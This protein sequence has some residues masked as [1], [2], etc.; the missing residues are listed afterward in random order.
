MISN[1]TLSLIGAFKSPI[2]ELTKE[3]KAE[4]TFFLDNGMSDYIENMSEKY[5]STKTFLFR[6][7]K[8]PFYDVYFSISL[9]LGEKKF[10]IKKIDDL[11][12]ECNYATII[13]NAGSGKSMLM[14]HLFLTSIESLYKIPIVIDLRSLNDFDGNLTDYLYQIIFNNK[15]SPNKKI[16]ERILSSDEFIF[17]LDGFDELYSAHKNKITSD[18]DSFIDRYSKNQ[19]II[20]SRPNSGI[21]SFPRFNNYFVQSLST[22]EI[23]SFVD[24][25]LRHEDYQFLA[26][27][28]KKAILRPENQDYINFL[29]SPLLLSMFIL[30]FNSY[31]ELPKKKSK[32]YWNV[33][34][35]LSTKHDAFTKKGGFQHERKTGLQNDDFETILKWF[36]YIS[37]F[38]GK[39]TFDSQY[40]TSKLGEI[41]NN[42][43]LKVNVQD[44]IDD[45]TLAISIII[46]DGIEYRFPHKSMQEYF[47]A[48]LIKD[49][50][51]EV[52]EKIYA[53]KLNL[54]VKMTF[55]GYENFWNLCCEL[56]KVNF[57]NFF[58]IR[59]LENFLKRL[60]GKND[61]T[62]VKEFYKIM[63]FA[64]GISIKAKDVIFNS[65]ILFGSNVELSVLQYIDLLNFHVLSLNSV[66]KNHKQEIDAVIK[67]KAYHK[68]LKAGINEKIIS[69]SE[70]WN[71]EF[72]ELLQKTGI[73]ENVKK[74]I[75]QIKNKVK[76]L[77]KEVLEENKNN[78]NLLDIK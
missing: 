46:I 76:Q 57:T 65:I 5:K 16:L 35:T 20:S 74:Y 17:L 66:Y 58:L 32:F 28:V 75:N 43:K 11:F 62:K 41:K 25:Q 64:E 49:Q 70:V 9:S 4:V 33:F 34:D 44:L 2:I 7:E 19:F 61:I 29:G 1:E 56:D 8:V 53:E 30:T 36:S 50:P 78:L 18:L 63:G 27:K 69:Y 31:P 42:F 13:G 52:K 12:L 72:E 14:K 3:L 21:E 6:N 54:Q 71:S 26:E 59:V 40:L 10:K 15:L 37:L 23:L 24:M 73:I 22:K 45:L 55:G 48:S 51:P 77:K 60:R 38:E 68:N 47:C 39:N 67:N